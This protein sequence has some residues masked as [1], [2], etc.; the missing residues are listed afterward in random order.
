MEGEMSSAR[1]EYLDAYFLRRLAL[2]QRKRS[3][4]GHQEGGEIE[5]HVCDVL[6]R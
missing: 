5:L 2:R 3:Q 4:Q 1:I 6:V